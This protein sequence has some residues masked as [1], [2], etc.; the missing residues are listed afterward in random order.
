MNSQAPQIVS[1]A[2]M[3]A[4]FGATLWFFFVQSPVLLRR[5]GRD[6]FVP[7]QMG[8][9]V[10]LFRFLTATV[11][12]GLLAGVLALA[13]DPIQLS[14]AVLATLAV[15]ANRFAVVPRALRA[16]GRGRQKVKGR[17][18]EASTTTF[19]SEG[20]GDATRF[21]HRLVVAFVVLMLT[22]IVGHVHALI[23]S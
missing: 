17:D 16:G 7:L 8:L 20:V 9:T 10:T 11:T 6:A 19:A 18:D 22:G 4:A 2:T 15:L 3:A 14:W 23:Q 5:M 12:L 21:Y 13:S 1:L